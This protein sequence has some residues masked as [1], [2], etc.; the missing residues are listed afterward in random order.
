MPTVTVKGYF[1]KTTARGPLGQT[2][3]R[4]PW[5]G[6]TDFVERQVTITDDEAGR[7]CRCSL[8]GRMTV[9]PSLH[10]R[11]RGDF[12]HCEICDENRDEA[13][14]IT[15]WYNGPFVRVTDP[16]RLDEFLGELAME[17]GIIG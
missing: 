6:K 7:L 4:Y 12:P 1:G 13:G 14:N 17:Q 9:N 15:G 10:E 8:C 16:N 5:Q 11:A 2:K 3:A